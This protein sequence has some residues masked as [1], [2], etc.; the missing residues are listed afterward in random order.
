[1]KV[2]VLALQGSF[3]EHVAMLGRMGSDVTPVEVRLPR[4]LEGLDALIMPGGESTT[5]AKLAV[6][7]GLMEPIRAFIQSGKP[8]WGT[9]A[10]LIFL[11]KDIGRDQPTLAMMDIKVKRN[12]FGRQAESFTV[13]LNIAG[14]EGAPFTGVF[15]RAPM[16]ESVGEGVEVL[17]QL[18]DGT[19]VAARQGNMLATSFHPELTRDTR[20]HALFLASTIES[21]K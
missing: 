2:G 7:H 12:A 16:I 15:I 14:L 10:G 11:A 1:M 19:I 17:A 13:G 21:V 4:D 5:F 3:S 9:C 18:D 20:V 6:W 8:T